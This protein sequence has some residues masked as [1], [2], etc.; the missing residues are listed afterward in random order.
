MTDVPRKLNPA[1]RRASGET[2][3]NQ[4]DKV[5]RAQI[6]KERTASNAK[7]ARLRALRLAKEVAD[8]ETAQ[9]RAPEKAPPSKTGT[10]RVKRVR[11]AE[12]SD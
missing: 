10:V 6:E 5:V 1:P 8:K 12:P 9:Q 3:A 7:T 2:L 11:G 4:R